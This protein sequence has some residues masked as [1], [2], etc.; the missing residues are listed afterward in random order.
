MSTDQ[1]LPVLWRRRLSFLL[2]FAIVLGTV[3]GVTLQL[4]KKYSTT[5][6]LLVAP[7]RAPA[8]DF[9]LAQVSATLT[10][11]Y[12]ELLQ[13]A[14]TAEQVQTV[15]GP[16]VAG[17]DVGSRV[18][19]EL[20]DNQIIKVTAE[21]NSPREAQQIANTYAGVFATNSSRFSNAN[22]VRAFVTVAQSAVRP[23]QPSR[24]RPKLY[25][26]VGAVLAVIA[27]AAM[28]LL[29]HRFDQRLDLSADD[30]EVLGLPVIGRIPFAR[31]PLAWMNT[32]GK[33]NHGAEISADAYRLLLANLAFVNHGRR[34]NTLTV[35]SASAQ[36]GKSTTALSLSHAAAGSGAA[37]LVVDADLRQPSLAEKL[38]IRDNESRAGFSDCLIG[39]PSTL[40]GAVAPLADHLDLLTSGSLPPNPSALLGGYGLMDFNSY[41]RSLYD[42]VVYD[43]PPVAIG[44]DAS[45]L[46]APSDG[47]ILVVDIHVTERK[48]LRQA[49]DQLRRAQANLLGIVLNRVS[50]ND[51]ESYYYARRAPTEV[52]APEPSVPVR[53]T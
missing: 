26:L 47:V 50:G 21:G 39:S 46:A 19:I 14:R 10:K 31:M 15:L 4:P 2:T 41:A 49:I 1:L 6:Y 20:G 5:A 25:L 18:D 52:S 3:G 8:T 43:T 38:G 37:T 11:T 34:P 33:T 36:E 44:A 29:R 45:L 24:P 48:A 42:L 16:Y 30:V 40:A 22:A 35:V 7:A 13:T 53:S 51:G 17:G 9:E 32:S 27:A 28:A 12:G 23:H